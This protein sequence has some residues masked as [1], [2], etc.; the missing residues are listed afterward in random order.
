M[1]ATKWVGGLGGWGGGGLG[2]G[3]GE[4]AGKHVESGFSH[5]SL[6]KVGWSEGAPE[7]MRLTWNPEGRCAAILNHSTQQAEPVS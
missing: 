1:V 5:V 3:R 2:G 6:L 4:V 7:T